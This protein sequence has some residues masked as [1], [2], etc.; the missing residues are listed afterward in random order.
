MAGML[1][2]IIGLVMQS[3]LEKMTQQGRVKLNEAFSASTL[4]HTAG[5]LQ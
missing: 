3:I 1:V 2:A 5:G 4:N